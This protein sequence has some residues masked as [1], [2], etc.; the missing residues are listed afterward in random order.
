MKAIADLTVPVRAIVIDTMRRAIPGKSENDQK[1]VS[2]FVANCDTLAKHFNCLVTAVHHSPRSDNTRGSGSNA[3]DTAAD[4]MWQVTR[5]EGTSRANVTI[6][7][8]KDG[9][10][11][12]DTWAFELVDVLIGTDRSGKPIETCHVEI[13]QTP[14][15]R[16]STAKP[17]KRPKPTATEQRMMDILV[18]AVD[19]AGAFVTNTATVPRSTKAITRDMARLYAANAGFWAEDQNEDSRRALLS[20]YLNKLAGKQVIGLTAEH[21]WIIPK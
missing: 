15:A 18:R 16:K 5:T 2:A 1:D 3:L 21:V 14:E 8:M 4:A 19:E 13:I 7:A 6:H 11:E 17:T 10:S 9:S 20:H 12:G